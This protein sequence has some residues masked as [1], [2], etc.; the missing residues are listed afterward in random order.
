MKNFLVFCMVIFSMISV[1]NAA[2]QATPKCEDK[3]HTKILK[4]FLQDESRFC[5]NKESEYCESVNDSYLK[6]TL[7]Y[8]FNEIKTIALS[9]KKT[10]ICFAAY[11]INDNHMGFLYLIDKNGI[12]KAMF[13]KLD[14]D[15]NL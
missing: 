12:V 4:E 15:E 8:N 1:V 3:K 2:P 14:L 11:N 7:E 10:L 13:S 5:E 9:P 6:D